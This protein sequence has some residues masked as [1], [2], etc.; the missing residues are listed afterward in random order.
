VNGP[1]TR[2]LTPR[3]ITVQGDRIV[4]NP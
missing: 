1:A 3:P 4:L 2:A